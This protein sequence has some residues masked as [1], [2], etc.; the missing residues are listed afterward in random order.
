VAEE[1]SRPR[2]T[3]LVDERDGEV[4]G[5]I[6]I[7][8]VVDEIQILEVAVAPAA[9]RRGVATS[10]L[11]AALGPEHCNDASVA[12]LEVRAGNAA[13]IGLYEKEGFAAVGRRRRFYSDGEDAVLMNRQLSER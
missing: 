8:T 9:R 4:A 7:W 1:L 13:A 2:A 11:R 10:L 5:W 6:V 12:M 3:V